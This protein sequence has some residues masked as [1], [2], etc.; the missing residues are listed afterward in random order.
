MGL[1]DFLK[2]KET[3]KN[4]I[5]PIF[6]PSRISS[7]IEDAKYLKT[8]LIEVTTS[9][10]YCG[11]CAK[12]V[13]RIFSISGK[14]R[15]FPALPPN[16]ASCDSGHNFSCLSFYPYIDGVNEPNFKCK[17]VIKYSNRPF[18]DGRTPEEIKRYDDWQTMIAEDEAKKSKTE[19]CKKEYYWLQSHLPAFCPKSLS[20]YVRM[21]NTNSK[22]YQ[23]LVAEAK[24]LGKQ[25]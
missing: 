10:P 22:N 17:N 5:A 21:K 25:L 18:V 15:R 19:Q 1:F 3:P 12:Y 20:G 7:A 8:D 4:E 23:K 13:N 14:D 9:S 16:F 2:K 6:Y 11:E 24:K